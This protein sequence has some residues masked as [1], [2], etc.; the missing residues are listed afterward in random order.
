MLQ[1]QKVPAI[2]KDCTLF[3]TEFL[4]R[5]CDYQVRIICMLLLY[6]ITMLCVS[7][8][9]PPDIR[10]TLAAAFAPCFCDITKRKEDMT[11][12]IEMLLTV[13]WDPAFDD[14]QSVNSLTNVVTDI[15]EEAPNDELVSH[16]R[17]TGQFFHE[18]TVDQVDDTIEDNATAVETFH[19]SPTVE[20]DRPADGP[21]WSA[22]VAQED[23][24]SSLEFA[25]RPTN[26]AT[27]SGP[28]ADADFNDF[29]SDEFD[30]EDDGLESVELE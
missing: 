29:S 26:I 19:H 5:V 28:P 4:R 2:N 15:L 12:F 14:A 25:S 10:K 6:R 24:L 30:I 23:V 27:M 7:Q 22:E 3:I 8:G 13:N 1:M 18:D 16:S 11:K 21:A 20:N 9:S 17:P